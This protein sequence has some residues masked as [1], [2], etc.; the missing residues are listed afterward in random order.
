MVFFFEST[1]LNLLDHISKF[2]RTNY[3]ILWQ[4]HLKDTLQL[5]I[6]QTWINI[7]TS[8]FLSKLL[9]MK[10]DESARENYLHNNLSLLFEEHTT[11][12][13]HLL[14]YAFFSQINI[15]FKFNI[16]LFR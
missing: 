8:Y 9:K 5:K 15:V 1:N 7:G 14:L 2:F 4:R 16:V 13:F 12:T 10:F 6:L 3:E 11:K